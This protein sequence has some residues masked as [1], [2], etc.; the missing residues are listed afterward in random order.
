MLLREC[1]GP[2]STRSP[3]GSVRPTISSS[4][5]DGTHPFSGRSASS[6]TVLSSELT[7]NVRQRRGALSVRF[8]IS[9]RVSHHAAAPGALQHQ[10]RTLPGSGGGRGGVS[11]SHRHGGEI[12]IPSGILTVKIF[13]TYLKLSR[14][15]PCSRYLF[16]IS[17]RYF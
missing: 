15:I 5:L 9:N 12:R 10:V 8:A 3:T 14:D 11:L 6:A 13:M 17:C 7:S 1:D 2:I 4:T 16:K